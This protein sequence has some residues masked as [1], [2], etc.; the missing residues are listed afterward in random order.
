LLKAPVRLDD[1]WVRRRG[2]AALSVALLFGTVALPGNDRAGA[3]AMSS[4][5]SESVTL[6][7]L[8]PTVND[9]ALR[10][11]GFQEVVVQAAWSSIEPTKGS[12]SNVAL[13]QVQQAIDQARAAGLRASL[14]VGVQYAPSWIFGVGGGTRFE[15]QYGDLFSGPPGSGNDVANAV[16]DMNVR[17][18]LG[19]YLAYLGSHLQGLDSVRIGGGPDN[20]LRYPSGGSGSEP[21]AYWFFDSSSQAEL[22]TSV[23]GWVPDTKTAVQAKEFLASYD[24]ALVDYGLWLA[25]QTMNDFP[26]SVKVELLL[27][28]W[29]ERPGE[30]QAAEKELLRSTPDEVNQGL[31]WVDLLLALPRDDRIVA[32]T[33][34]G[35]ATQG[36]SRNPDPAAFIHAHLPSGVLAGGESTGNGQT[37]DAGEEQMFADAK[38]WS[39]YV[40]NWYF[41]GQG[42]TAGSVGAT[43]AGVR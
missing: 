39:W 11:D 9:S 28:G 25:R 17:V 31:D 8:A 23:K 22:R 1:L 34:Y 21:D 24:T 18:R 3:S 6:G 26:V 15:D 10:S 38:A 29:G 42:E 14:D 5:E 36:T 32:Y 2:T 37:S 27:P 43:F 19:Q 4:P 13:G 7:A 33:T 40:V 30:V 41:H 12:F 35:D 20:E 16:T